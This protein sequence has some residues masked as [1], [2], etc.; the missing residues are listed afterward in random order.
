MGQRTMSAHAYCKKK[1]KKMN[2]AKTAAALIISL[3][4][5]FAY[6]LKYWSSGHKENVN[7]CNNV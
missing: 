7:L 2:E 4:I 6:D 1:K 5:S 3:I